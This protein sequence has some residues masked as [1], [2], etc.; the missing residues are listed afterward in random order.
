MQSKRGTTSGVPVVYERG[1]WRWEDDGQPVSDFPHSH[2][3]ENCGLL[4][5]PDGED[6]CLGHLPG[7]ITACCGH[8]KFP[9]YIVFE[10]RTK[11][12]FTL[13]TVEHR[14]SPSELSGRPW[15]ITDAGKEEEA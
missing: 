1:E 2:R 13:L 8:G 9:G 7:V 5:G 4:P 15:V 3:C 10:N 6:G 12:T 11:I 14:T